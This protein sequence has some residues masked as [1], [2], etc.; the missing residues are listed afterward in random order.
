M[1]NEHLVVLIKD[2]VDVSDNMLRLWEQNRGFIGKIASGYRGYEEMDDL[3]QQGYIGLCNAVSSYRMEEGIPFINYAAF[4]IRQSMERYIENCGGIVRIP[5][6]ERQRHRRY[7]K[8]LREFEGSTGRKP[9]KWEMCRYMGMSLKALDALER[10][11]EL[12]RV[13]SLDRYVGEDGDTTLGEMI[14]ADGDM[15]NAVL[16]EMEKEELKQALWSMVDALPNNQPHVIRSIYREGKTLKATGETIGVSVERARTIKNSAIRT[17]RSRRRGLL[18]FLPEMAES[19][20]YRH[21]GVGE[22]NRTWTSSTEL[23]ALKIY[24]EITGHV[25]S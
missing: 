2:G 9:D 1:T 11:M 20:A 15:E 12:G 22:F 3:R 24:E 21:N 14:P 13:G 8:L 4:W 17:L 23:A 19:M 5:S 25:L 18:A 16:D 7:R 10:N 6:H